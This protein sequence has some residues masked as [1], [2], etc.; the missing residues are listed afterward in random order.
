MEYPTLFTGGTQR[1][2]K[3][4]MQEPES[5]TVHEAGHQFWYGLVGNNE[6]EA[7]W[8]DEGF[9]TFSQNQALWFQYGPRV[10]TTRF[11][12]LPFEGVPIARSPGGSVISDW[13]TGRRFSLPRS[14]TLEPLRVDGFLD[15]WRDQP[16]LSYGRQLTDPRDTER[17]NY[18]TDPDADPVD[19][20]GWMYRDH[21]S[22]RV[23]SYR[24]TA[25][26]LRSLEGLVGSD[27][28]LRGMRNYSEQ[29]RYRH[30]YPQDFFNAFLE[31]AKVDVGWYFEQAFRS[32]AT[33]D[34]RVDVAQKQLS[35]PRGWFPA[36]D[37]SWVKLG[38]DGESGG[39]EDAD[40]ESDHAGKDATGQAGSADVAVAR[41]RSKEW[42]VDVVV[43][44]GDAAAVYRTCPGISDCQY[45]FVT[46]QYVGD[47]VVDHGGGDPVYYWNDL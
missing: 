2:T 21:Q 33:L 38:R 29:W 14:I 7:A 27:N 17:I 12:G 25:T 18:L 15:W 34:W 40:D 20:L 23:N 39:D 22:Y 30:P 44:P 26:A 4:S 3:R 45:S 6:F 42:I 10:A 5:V 28:F 43:T 36:T 9:N 41:K 1:F 11:V 24:R 13:L 32:V 46:G 47:H 31:G 8:L 35:D 19:R 16:L 37:G